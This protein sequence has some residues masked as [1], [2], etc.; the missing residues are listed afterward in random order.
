MKRTAVVYWSGTGCTAAMAEAVAEG[1]RSAGGSAD[2]IPVPEFRTADAG[3]YDALAFGCPAMGME[4]L[5]EN[6]FE[7]AFAAA[8]SLLGGKKTVLF[9]SYGWGDGTWMRNWK[10][11][12]ADAGASV[13]GSVICPGM[14]SDAD[15]ENC[16]NLG[17]MLV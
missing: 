2:L 3:A 9:G 15:L 10:A 12:T 4:A 14:P 6:E 8:E 11:R 13:C 17:R 5:E 16:R 7:P 1:I